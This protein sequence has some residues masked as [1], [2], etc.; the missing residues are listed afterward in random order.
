V[1][2]LVD[3][4]EDCSQMTISDETDTHRT[5]GDETDTH[6]NQLMISDETDT[7]RTTGD[8]TD[9]H[10]NQLMNSDETDT[11]RTIQQL[12]ERIH[13]LEAVSLISYVSC[14]CTVCFNSRA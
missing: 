4:T 3:K 5:T 11:H 9:T 1:L 6:S 10:S 14:R 12:C 8:E 13:E 2:C 7:H